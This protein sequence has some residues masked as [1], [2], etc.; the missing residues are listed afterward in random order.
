MGAGDTGSQS[1]N[2]NLRKG[3][4][5]AN[6]AI[7]PVGPGGRI[8]ITTHAGDVQLIADVSGWFGPT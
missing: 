1:S 8:T 2:V 6:L 7:V 3:E 4:T 5:R